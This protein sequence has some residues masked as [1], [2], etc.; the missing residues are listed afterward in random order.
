MEFLL[1]LSPAG[2]DIYSLI[3]QK[4]K[5]VE[6]TP[7]CR[8]HQIY[9]WYDTDQRTMTICT[10]RI[11]SGPKPHY[12]FNETLFHEAVH[13]AQ[14]CKTGMKYVTP[15][16]I[17]PSDM[18]LNSYRTVDLSTSTRL[19]GNSVHKVEHEAF[20]MEDKPEK[21]EYVIKKYCFAEKKFLF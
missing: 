10:S 15:F 13:I 1:Y 17:N 19:N 8:K 14:S 20:W 16:H 12:Y 7:I 6:N 9:G 5:V 4:V 18:P 11:K 3:A 2:K 21:V